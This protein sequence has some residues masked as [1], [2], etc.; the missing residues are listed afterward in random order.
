MAAAAARS[1]RTR[2]V[3]A[4]RMARTRAR[5]LR[6]ART[7]LAL[8]LALVA[9]PR[10]ALADRPKLVVIVAK[11]SPVKSL[12]RA[13]LR[14]IFLGEAV[15]V[16]DTS[17]APFNSPPGTPPRAGFDQAVLGMS[18]GEVGRF[19]VDRKVRGQA[20]APRSLPSLAHVLK[21]VAKFPGAISYVPADQLTAAVQP[22]AV[23]G[24]AHTDAR[25]SIKVP[26]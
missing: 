14:R 5:A 10:G 15:S 2:A 23:D 24:L 18:P 26:P 19:W 3:R 21:V 13:E 6:T 4:T 20:P 16:S 8:L 25:Y 7:L 12:T 9:A 1:D 22:V 17:L 11:G